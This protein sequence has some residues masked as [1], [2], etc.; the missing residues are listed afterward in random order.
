MKNLEECTKTA[1]EVFNDAT[2]FYGGSVSSRTLRDGRESPAL[3]R[4]SG[5][6]LM[7]MRQELTARWRR[8]VPVADTNSPDPESAPTSPTGTSRSDMF[9][10]SST[11][12]TSDNYFRTSLNEEPIQTD[13]TIEPKV[14]EQNI[15][16]NMRQL[17][18]QSFFEGDYKK[19]EELL[20]R[21][22]S[23]LRR[24]E[25]RYFVPLAET[26][27]ILET[28]GLVYC[29][30]FDW[31]Q[32]ERIVRLSFIGRSNVLES[33]ALAYI[34]HKKWEQAE[35]IL[36]RLVLDRSVDHVRLLNSMHTLSHVYME[37]SDY[38]NAER[39]CQS[40]MAEG[41]RSVLYD[42]AVGLL[43]KIHEGQEDFKMYNPRA[44]INGK[45]MSMTV[46][47]RKYVRTL[48]SCATW[49]HIP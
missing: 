1:F 35:A 25:G 14:R 34:W 45:S 46:A 22:W 27:E 20:N 42:M 39:W 19:A 33:L 13:S 15:I 7:G 5:E 17:A 28:L 26:D 11:G 3:R 38:K 2:T 47:K 24:W 9:E 30:L 8:D 12:D 4:G 29:Q 6:D 43:V 37:K 41:R 23:E 48:K 49:I 18:F 31:K 44:G 32:A 21:T 16:Q 36:T 10:G 40:V